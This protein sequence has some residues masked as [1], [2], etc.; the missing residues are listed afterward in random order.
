MGR[1]DLI[2][3]PIENGYTSTGGTE[4]ILITEW[5]WR[6]QPINLYKASQAPWGGHRWGLADNVSVTPHTAPRPLPALKSPA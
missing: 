4:K 2:Y 5:L 6:L 3:Q 1:L